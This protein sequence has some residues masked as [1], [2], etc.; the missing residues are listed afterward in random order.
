MLGFLSTRTRRVLFCPLLSRS[1][2]TFYNQKSESASYILGSCWLA[3]LPRWTFSFLG[4]RVNLTFLAGC[5]KLSD[6]FTIGEL[7]KGHGE[8]VRK[9]TPAHVTVRDP[10]R[11]L[12]LSHQRITQLLNAASG[13]YH[14]GPATDRTVTSSYVWLS[15]PTALNRTQVLVIGFFGL[16]WAALVA[17]LVLSPE[18]YTQTL[19]QVGG[20]S[21]LIE[22]SFLIALS[23]FIALLVVGVYRRWRWTFWLILVA[24]FVGVLRLPAPALQ[25]AEIVPASGPTWYEALQGAIGVVQFLIALA[26]LAG[27]RKAGVWGKF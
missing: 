19:R 27:Y 9:C 2:P 10:G 1:C 16:V 13:K 21:R 20:D 8:R 6:L 26:M 24:F 25:L 17:I 4:L 3:G 22:A 15:I 11:L 23:A 5:V 12:G 18:V 14:S 7:A